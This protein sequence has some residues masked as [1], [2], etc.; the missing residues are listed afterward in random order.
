MKTRKIMLM[1]V[2]TGLTFTTGT[3]MVSCS[4]SDDINDIGKNCPITLTTE[5]VRAESRSA[6]QSLQNNQ[7]ANGAQVGIFLLGD[8]AGTPIDI[9]F[10]QPLTYTADGT[11]GLANEQYW[12]SDGGSLH[13]FGVYPANAATAYNATGVTFSVQTDQS[14]D[15][16]FMASDLMTGAPASNPVARTSAAVPL[17]FTHLLSKV[18]I[19]LTA[20]GGVAASDLTNADVYIM[21]MKCTTTFNMTDN[22][23]SAATGTATDIKTGKG[24]ITSAIVIPGQTVAAGTNFIKV[25]SG[26]KNYIYQMG[27]AT[28]I[29]QS[30][31]YTY[32]LSVEETGLVL[33][34][35]S[36]TPWTAVGPVN[37]VAIIQ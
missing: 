17:T 33:S 26:T 29:G 23:V 28:T 2:L 14:S 11:G 19:N 10:A 15:A 12:P 9:G 21:G 30:S 20:G 5:T 22:T 32:N 6:D 36:I 7:F 37:G 25:V 35:V 34:G 31:N 13:I 1:A 24:A 27:S 18:D 4:D 16:N 8:N 3:T